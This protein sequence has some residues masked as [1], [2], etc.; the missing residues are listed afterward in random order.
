MIECHFREFSEFGSVISSS[1]KKKRKGFYSH[2]VLPIKGL[3]RDKWIVLS[4]IDVDYKK[5]LSEGLSEEEIFQ[6]CVDFLN[7]PLPR[8][9]YAKKTPKPLYGQLT[10]YKA[11][12]KEDENGEY[13]EAEFTTDQRKN[14]NFWRVG[15]KYGRVKIPYKLKAK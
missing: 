5:Y 13:I 4:H 12:F 15:I 11:K 2:S 1:N 9:K 3:G 8:K 10:P 14:K 6:Q 7:K